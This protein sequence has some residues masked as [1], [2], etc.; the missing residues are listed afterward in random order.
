MSEESVNI[1]ELTASIVDEMQRVCTSVSPFSE[2][3]ENGGS[4][5]FSITRNGEEF[6]GAVSIEDNAEDF[7]FP[8]VSI[9]VN[10]C[11]AEQLSKEDIL[12]LME[13][14]SNFWRASLVALG[15]DDPHCMLSLQYRVSADI[16]NPS[17]LT[18][19]I[20]HLIGQVGMFLDA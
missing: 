17:E 11:A 3:D 7:G 12:R 19:C 10:L 1:N 5:I 9:F 2:N 6:G 16:F 4:W 15:A 8:T 20:D 18:E 14:S 13:S